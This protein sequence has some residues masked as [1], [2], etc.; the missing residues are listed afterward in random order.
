MF[1]KIIRTIVPK[2]GPKL[3]GPYSVGK[4]YNGTAYIS[5]Q[6]GINPLTNELVSNCV[7]EQ[8]DQI[9]KNLDQILK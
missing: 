6:L 7:E 3:I 5:G 2:Q 8:T 4:I 9:L 1:R